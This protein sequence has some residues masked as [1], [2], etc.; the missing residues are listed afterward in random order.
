MKAISIRQPWATLVAEGVKDIE[1]RD[2]RWRPMDRVAIHASKLVDWAGLDDARVRR[3]AEFSARRAGDRSPLGD[4]FALGHVLAVAA[5]TSCHQVQPGCCT[6]TWGNSDARFH[7]VI[8]QVQQLSR[9]VPVAGKLGL[10]V[11]PDEA[12]TDVLIQ[13][14]GA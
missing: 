7:L 13:L 8:D 6:S 5:I 10:W 3:G 4:R 14:G 9:P 2:Q 12:A 1:N 11:L